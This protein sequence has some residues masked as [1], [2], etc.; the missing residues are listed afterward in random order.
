MFF[1]LIRGVAQMVDWMCIGMEEA[2]E[3]ISDVVK[4]LE[5]EKKSRIV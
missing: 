2:V 1:F 5:T 4:I 3:Q